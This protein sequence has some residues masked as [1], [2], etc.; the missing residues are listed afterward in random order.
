MSTVARFWTVF[1]R[2]FSCFLQ[3]INKKLIEINFSG[4]AEKT[5][6]SAEI[7]EKLLSKKLKISDFEGILKNLEKDKTKNLFS[8]IL[9]SSI[10]QLRRY[11]TQIDSL[12]DDLTHAKKINN[13][14]MRK[15]W[16]LGQKEQI[17][18]AEM[19]K[20]KREMLKMRKYVKE[21][22]YDWEENDE[23]EKKRQKKTAK[24]PA[25][26]QEPSGPINYYPKTPKET[27]Y[28]TESPTPS[29]NYSNLSEPCTSNSS[30]GPI[31]VE[32]FE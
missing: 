10:Y 7:L 18:E 4:M 15:V 5:P 26:D 17:L 23:I 11:Q 24:P 28:F 2:F 27:L 29:K 16:E 19:A 12:S 8:E 32:I 21:N 1:Y 6:N 3:K 13:A 31:I 22:I 9:E 25:V 14:K 20:S 30:S